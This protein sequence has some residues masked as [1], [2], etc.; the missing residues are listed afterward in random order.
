MNREQILDYWLNQVLMTNDFQRV[1]LAGDASFR[2]YY[3]IFVREQR[4]VV[5]DAPPPEAPHL[6]MEIASA[7]ADI[8]I[9]VPLI[10]ASELTNG[11]L[12]LSDLGDRLYLPE[13]NTQTADVLYTD[14][15]Q[16]LL[17]IQSC[18]APVPQFDKPLLQ[19]QLGIFREWFLG[20]HKGLTSDLLVSKISPAKLQILDTIYDKLIKTIED[21]PQVFV[22]RDYHSRNLMILEN[23]NPG[24]IDFQDAVI[25]PITYDLVSL[26]QDCYIIWPR[27][28]VV[29]WVADYQNLATKHGLLSKTVSRSEFLRWFDW[30][31]LQRHLKNLGIFSRLNYRDGKIQYLKDIPYV[32]H[33]VQETSARYSE[34]NDL[35]TFFETLQAHEMVGI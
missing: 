14:A 26:L 32:L 33:Y 11:F 25:G 34:L 7:L 21:Q 15:F 30:T 27:A 23:G 22:H 9:S 13:L 28:R 24:V 1:S 4:Y 20:K 18:K 31:G 8:G 6:F 5:M 35:W 10:V 19:R 12:L 29:D 2:R 3:R 17:K 16:A